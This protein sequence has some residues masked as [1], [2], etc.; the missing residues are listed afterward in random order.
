MNISEI[1]TTIATFT[2]TPEYQLTNILGDIDKTSGLIK[3]LYRAAL[4]DELGN[5]TEIALCEA[6]ALSDT[7]L[8]QICNQQLSEMYQ[9]ISE[10]ANQLRD[11]RKTPVFMTDTEN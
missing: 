9:K 11:D 8:L 7:Y 3:T 10:I 4:N 1:Q 5:R 2:K 6:D